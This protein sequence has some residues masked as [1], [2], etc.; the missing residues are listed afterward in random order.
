[1]LL[2]VLVDLVVQVTLV[3]PVEVDLPNGTGGMEELVEVDLVEQVV[4]S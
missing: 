4:L 1:M 3:E 2:V